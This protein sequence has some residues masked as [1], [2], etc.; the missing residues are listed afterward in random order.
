MFL[1]S[2]LSSSSILTIFLSFHKH[3]EKV[4]IAVNSFLQKRLRLLSLLPGGKCCC[5]SLNKDLELQRE[6]ILVG[7]NRITKVMGDGAFEL[8]L[9][10]WAGF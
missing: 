3:P 4:G 1:R 10:R 9:G 7:G 6:G 8:G 2:L 5:R